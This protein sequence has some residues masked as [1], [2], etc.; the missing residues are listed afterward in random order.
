MANTLSTDL[1]NPEIMTEAVRGAFAQKTA[2]MG[3]A[4]A[5]LGVVVVNGS[6]PQ[7]GPEAVGQTIK[8]PYFGTLGEFESNGEDSEATPKKIKQT[9]EQGTITRD[10]LAFEVSR[11]AQ[12]NALVDPAV[13]DPYAESARQVL[14]AAE[15]AMD[16]RIMTAAAASGVYTK[17]VYS[18]STPRQLDWDLVVDAKVDGW[19]D[20]Q[21]DVVALAVHSRTHADLLKLKDSTG[22]PFG[23]DG[24]PMLMTTE[25]TDGTVVTRFQGLR[26]VVS[27]KLPLT[28]STM[29]AVS[30]SGSSPP[31]LTITGTPLGSFN[32]VIDC[33]VGGAHE[34]ATYR[35][36]TDGGQTWSANITTAAAT[37]AQPLTD[38]ATDSIVG[39]N[40]ATGLSV[41]FAAGTFNADNLWTSTAALQVTSLLLKRRALAFWYASGQMGMETDKNI[42]KHSDIAAMH[43]YGVA[44][45]YRRVAE[46]T[47]PGVVPI[48]HNVGGF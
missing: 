29:G 13:G 40:G 17:N 12:G 22:M 18:A 23:V 6:M 38:T 16:R 10:T 15:R 24:K 30:S 36:S 41:A 1:F 9:Y 35:F 34:T 44:H 33:V 20:E 14:S 31:V 5:Q 8:V 11:W 28:N 7:G 46:T 19:G 39:V 27:D 25:G 37:V 47:H 48:I 2:F 21:D 43:L 42:L 26:V 45:R 4:L 32:L 3:S